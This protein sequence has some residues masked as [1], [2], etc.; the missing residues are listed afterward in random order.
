MYGIW[1]PRRYDMIS[2]GI[3][4]NPDGVF[5]PAKKISIVKLTFGDVVNH[6]LCTI[7]IHCS[8]FHLN[9]FP[10]G[11]KNPMETEAIRRIAHYIT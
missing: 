2:A 7:N 9:G 8:I 5:P 4:L 11:V 1:S 3:S 10:A 6:G